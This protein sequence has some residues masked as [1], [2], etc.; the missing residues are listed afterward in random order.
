M[1]WKS[2]FLLR[3]NQT[4]RDTDMKKLILVTMAAAVLLILAACGGTNQDSA[5]KVGSEAPPAVQR[6]ESSSGEPDI[7]ETPVAESAITLTAGEH[8]FSATLLDNE[9]ARQLA[10]LFPLTLEMSELNGNE[11]YFYLDGSLPTD[12]HR[13]GQI[14]A[15][16]LMLYGDNC[17]VLFYESF[18]SGYSYTRLGSVDDPAGLAEALGT[19]G[20][21]VTFSV[22][23]DG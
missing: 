14:N 1:C 19:G 12:S 8:T 21:E 15:G 6:P 18:S 23:D 11:K 20:V 7:S 5:G 13:P 17:L 22:R 16:D 10:E 4:E 3:R 2:N 9:T